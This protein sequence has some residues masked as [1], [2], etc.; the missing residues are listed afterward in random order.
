MKKEIVELRQLMAEKGIDAYYV[1]SGDFHSS[2]YVNDYFK[3]RAFMTNLTGES[4]ELIVT[5]D[6]AWVWT[7]GRYFL[8]AEEQLAGTEIE[9]MRMAEPGV[10]TVEEFMTELVR[11][12]NGTQA[13]RKFVLGFDGRVVPGSFDATAKEI[14]G[15]F[16]NVVIK[17]DEDLVDTVWKDRPEL[18]PTE[19]YE[20][21]LT[22]AGISAEDKI[23]AVRAEMKKE[24]TDYLLITDLMESAWLFNLRAA[25]ILYTPVF[26]AYTILT[27]DSVRLYVMDGALKNGLPQ[28]LDFVEVHDYND[29]YKDVAELSADKTLWLDSGSVNY[30]LYLSIPEGMKLHDALTPVAL[31]KVIKNETEIASS[32]KAHIKDGEHV[33]GAQTRVKVVKNKVAPPFR[34]AEFDVI[35]GRGISREGEILDMGVEA[36]IIKK[37][38]AWFSWQDGRLGQGREAAKQFLID[39]PDTAD[40]I[41]AALAP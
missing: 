1:P 30:A 20:L 15:E 41:A 16:D 23:A 24:G 22:S 10:P 2:E 18:K 33:L 4:G 11:K 13:D 27:Q 6:G 35:Y 21:P 39:N 3:A 28:H 19:I 26:F 9:L 40:A 37:S 7:D 8:Q 36:G 12:H 34:K 17:W 5:Q 14:F 38:G 31:M 32:R 29:I 25:D